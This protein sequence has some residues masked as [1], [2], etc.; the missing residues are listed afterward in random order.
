MTF[1]SNKIEP[2]RIPVF[3]CIFFGFLNGLITFYTSCKILFAA[4]LSIPDL[5]F[6]LRNMPQYLDL[7]FLSF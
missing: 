6:G 4:H 1:L 5:I 3:T 2:L 7:P